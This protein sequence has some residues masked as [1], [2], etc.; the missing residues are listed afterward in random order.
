MQKVAKVVTLANHSRRLA[1]KGRHRARRSV[2]RVAIACLLLF[3]AWQ[4]ILGLVPRLRT[5]TA[6]AEWGTVEVGDRLDATAVREDFVCRA[7]YR[8]RVYFLAGEGRRVAAG[9]VV[10]VLAKPGLSGELYDRIAGLCETTRNTQD[11]LM[12]ARDRLDSIYRWRETMQGRILTLAPGHLRLIRATRPGVVSSSLDGYENRLAFG[13]L[14]SFVTGALPRRTQTRR[15]EPGVWLNAGDPVYRLTDD[16]EMYLLAP[17][18]S[19]R[20]FS[21]LHPG[22]P[23]WVETSEDGEPDNAEVWSCGEKNVAI[24]VGSLLPAFLNER[25]RTVRFIWE[26]R[27]GVRVPS[28]A[29]AVRNDVVGVWVELGNRREFTPVEVAARNGRYAIVTGITEGTLVRW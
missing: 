27:N 7:P 6:V 3:G 9:E 2:I 24:H 1:A 17:R 15:I 22:R 16:F 26:R 10:A 19:H 12:V 28:G 14:E 18:P 13:T 8:A 5:R 23:V 11:E 21:L 29:L 4:V 25:T 20:D